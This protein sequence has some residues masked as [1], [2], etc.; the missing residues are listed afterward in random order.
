M[1]F[2]RLGW[3]NQYKWILVHLFRISNICLVT[4]TI[5]GT[6][7]KKQQRTKTWSCFSG[8]KVTTPK[9]K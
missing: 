1:A 3:Q 5:L 4:G 6:E 9:L 7:Y 8:E 2:L